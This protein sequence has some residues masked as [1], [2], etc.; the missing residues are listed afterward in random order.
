MA[1][2]FISYRR[3]DGGPYAGRLYDALVSHLDRD[4]VFFDIDSIGPG[5]DFRDVLHR[6]LS[7]CKVV[8]AIIGTRWSTVQDK[9]GRTRIT[10][11]L[12]YVRMEISYALKN[13]LK[14]IPV[15]VGGAAIPEEADLPPDL[16]ALRYRNAWDLSDRRFHQD[17]QILVDVIRKAL[18]TP[19]SDTPVPVTP[20]PTPVFHAPAAKKPPAEE[21][22]ADG[23]SLFPLYG[24][25]L[26]KTT[27]QELAEIGERTM[28][29]DAD[30]GEPYLCYEVNEIDFW[31]DEDSEIVEHMY[32]VTGGEVPTEWEQIG[33]NWENSYNQWLQWLK[34]MN[35]T[36][37]I[38]TPPHVEKWE[39]EDT[40]SAKVKGRKTSGLSHLIELDF[41]FEKGTIDSPSTVYSVNISSAN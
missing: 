20:A 1:G 26:G 21:Q 40:F 17:V 9:A 38:D 18:G 32:L 16:H 27:V 34:S 14:V 19:G 11:D 23:P 25:T 35:Y 37:E 2:I 6:T 31:Y 36:I 12:D 5:E 8:L 28:D 24:I 29:V 22:A 3:E 15:L 33:W 41:S 30:T 7:S 10:N 4:T 39:G 13:G